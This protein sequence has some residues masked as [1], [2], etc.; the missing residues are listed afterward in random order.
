MKKIIRTFLFVSLL[1]L[2]LN[3]CGIKK[4]PLSSD[5]KTGSWGIISNVGGGFREIYFSD[6]RNG[7]IVGNDGQIKHTIDG[8][9]TW[10]NQISGT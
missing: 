10:E 6:S 9:S 1:Y 5:I 3:N 4:D 8:G 7:W 2:L